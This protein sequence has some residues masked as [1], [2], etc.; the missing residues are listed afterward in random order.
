MNTTDVNQKVFVVDQLEPEVTAMLQAF[1]SRSDTSIEDRLSTLGTDSAK[2]KENLKK[3]YIGYGHSSIADCG[4]TTLFIE[5]VSIIAAKAIQDDPLY[6]GQET[7][8]RY[9][10]FEHRAFVSPF[11][12]TY[13]E[14]ATVQQRLV[15]L[16][17]RMR[18]LVLD[19]I[20]SAHPFYFNES[21]EDSSQMQLK[22]W[23][24]ATNARSFDIVRGLLPAG[25][26]TQLSWKGSL[27]RISERLNTLS[28]HPCSEI[29]MLAQSVNAQLVER[30]PSSFKPIA[31][32]SSSLPC[33]FYDLDSPCTD[34]GF[35]IGALHYS[36]TNF[37]EFNDSQYYKAF[38]LNRDRKTQV[39]NFFNFYGQ[40]QFEFLLDYGSFRDIQRHRNGLTPLPMLGAYSINGVPNMF[41]P[42]YLEQLGD[43]REEVESELSEIYSTIDEV[44]LE[45]AALN[46]DMHVAHAQMQYYYPMG[47]IV[48]VS[49][50]YGLAEAIYVS[51]L[52]TQATVHPTLRVVAHGIAEAVKEVFPDI[53][54]HI[55]KSEDGFVLRRGSQ[56]IFEQTGV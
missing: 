40:F 46:L 35:E 33:P 36:Y 32:D 16:Y 56:D 49:V 11:G 29:S 52:R 48:P 34:L 18:P 38:L 8:T 4:D 39:P 27:R 2:I 1:Y 19:R 12:S 51:E 17:A 45:C 53:A 42:W 30:Y 31:E 25:M 47:T 41:H 50:I 54:L 21:S 13:R 14:L 44:L 24:N 9:F 55:D 22:K 20:R 26:T 5:N 23:E 28:D 3:W 10:D 6:N 15:D 43:L 37:R 7:S